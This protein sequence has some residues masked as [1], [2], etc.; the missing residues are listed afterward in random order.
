M[1]APSS[2]FSGREQLWLRYRSN[3]P[4]HCIGVSR[5]LQST[6]MHALTDQLGHTQLRLSF[7]PYMVLVTEQG[8]RP[9]ELAQW[10]A[11]SKQA[12]NQTINQIEQAGYL[13]RT[14]DPQDGRARVV[15]LT[16]KGRELLRQGAELQ[17]IIDAELEQLLGSGQ[18]QRL[19][20][21]LSRL[22]RALELPAMR[23]P[24]NSAGAKAS[25]GGLLPR[26]SSYMMQRLMELTR[27]KGH[28]GLKM[29]YAQ[30]LNLI[31]PQGGRIQ[32]MARIQEVSKQAIA[33]VVRELEMLGYIRREPD[34]AD[35]RQ[36]LLVLSDRGMQL[37]TDS[38]DSV[39][40]LES[41]LQSSVGLADLADIQRSMA[42]LYCGLHLE[43]EVFGITP[44]PTNAPEATA[45]DLPLLARRLNQQLGPDGAAELARLLTPQAGLS[46]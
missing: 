46:L 37:L 25:P 2:T 28:A 23:V 38:V 45:Q 12:C 36:S 44:E 31:G 4:R 7:E 39:T 26:I 20:V 14:P 33:A 32:Q 27:A 6:L 10:L 16:N 35:A 30:V 8:A 21:S 11:I 43:E 15:V 9:G 18:L 3:L 22:Y 29:S 19:L 24:H 17:R 5:Y 13:A 40:E 34:G 41:E 1:I 42:D